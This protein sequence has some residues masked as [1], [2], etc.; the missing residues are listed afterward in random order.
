MFQ[1]QHFQKQAFFQK[2][3]FLQI[4]FYD[5]VNGTLT[6]ICFPN[7]WLD[8]LS[9]TVQFFSF[10]LSSSSSSATPAKPFRKTPLLHSSTTPLY[11]THLPP[12]SCIVLGHPPL[13]CFLLVS[14]PLSPPS[15]IVLGLPPLACPLLLY[16]P[17]SPP[18]CIESGLLPLASLYLYSILYLRPLVLTRAS[19]R[20]AALYLYSLLYLCPLVLTGP[21][22][23][24]L[25]STCIASSI[26]DLLYCFGRL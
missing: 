10:S 16:P 17:L 2:V 26:S 4:V 3:D 1:S 8:S 7:L 20:W 24:G 13:A 22:P 25:P 11:Y 15:C 14:P 19:S 9:L 21:P 18:S 23:S 5:C 12:P 6:L